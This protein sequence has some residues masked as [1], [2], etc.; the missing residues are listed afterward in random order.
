MAY[1]K[2]K[3]DA[4]I[5]DDSGSD[6]E[7]TIASL[8]AAASLNSP[9]FTGT[10]TV[11]TASAND[12]TTKAAS[13]AYVQA[14]LGDYLTTTTAASTYATKASPTFTGDVTVNAQGDLRFADNDSSN[15][16]AFQAPATVGSNVTWTLPAAD[17]SANQLLTT[18]GSGALTWSTVAGG[19]TSDSQ[20]NTVGGTNAGDSFTGTDATD[21]TMLGY[22]AGTATTTG[23]KSVYIGALAGEDVTTN[24]SNTFV[25]YGSGKQ[26][27]GGTNTFLGYEAGRD[28]TTGA[29]NIGIGHQAMVGNQAV[30]GAY[31][32]G[33]NNTAIGQYGFSRNLSGSTNVSIGHAALYEMTTGSNN[34]GM[35][36]HAGFDCTTGTHHV[37]IGYEAGNKV[38]TAD[39]SV[40]VG[41]SAGGNLTTGYMNTCVGPYAGSSITTCQEALMLGRNAGGT[42]SP[43]GEV[44]TANNICCLGSNDID[45]LYCADTSISSSD[46]RDKT[47]VTD[48]TH[49]LK[50]INQLKPI[51]YRWDK[52]SWYNEYNEDGSLKTEITPDGSKKRAR[53]H[54]GFLAQDV[55][56][57]EQADGFA[58][59]KDDM[60]VVNINEDATGYGLK[61]ERLVPV[62]VNAVKELSA[63]VETLE[64]KVAA[65]EAA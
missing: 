10:V 55:L 14:E 20:N 5:Y 63:K 23:D 22:N 31:I 24:G 32:T 9:T 26:V 52:R 48:F 16:V 49:G 15:W 19:I 58:S 37:L 39:Y 27:T 21:N 59:K 12:N 1:G 43:S 7:K 29:G 50:W 25:G 54:I 28:V 2:I 30:S 51:T 13:T 46:K 53:Q 65:L 42:S 36:Y 44:T 56:A 38:T 4:I 60:L 45:H 35:G 47:D 17:G 41:T 11:P 57:I 6:V 61:Y 64:T 62:L 18:N 8:A 34:I 40:C 33:S 3:A